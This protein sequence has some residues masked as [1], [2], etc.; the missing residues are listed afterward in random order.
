MPAD[1]L[2]LDLPSKSWRGLYETI[3][4]AV[5]GYNY[6]AWNWS[7]SNKPPSLDPSTFTE[8]FPSDTV[9]V[10]LITGTGDF[11]QDLVNTLNST[12]STRVVVKL[13]GTQA[14][15]QT[16]HITSF[17]PFGTQSPTKPY[18]MGFYNGTK[19]QG[20]LGGGRGASII[21]LDP[22]IYTQAQLTPL[23]TMV[24]ADFAPLLNSFGRLDGPDPTKP[25]LIGGVTFQGGDQP[26]LDTVGSDVPAV[27]PQPAPYQG[28]S[29]YPGSYYV[30]NDCEFLASGHALTSAPPFEMGTVSTQRCRG[31]FKRCD[32]DGRMAASLNPARPRRSTVWMGNDEG[33]IDHIDCWLHHS[34]VSRYA[35]NDEANSFGTSGHYGLLRCRIDHIADTQNVDPAQNGGVSLDGYSDPC[36]LGWESSN[37]QISLVDVII[38]QNNTHTTRAVPQHLGFTSTGRNSAGGHLTVTRGV[39]LNPGFPTVNNFLCVRGKPSNTLWVDATTGMDKTATVTGYDG[40][41]LKGRMYSG[42]WPPPSSFL[43]QYDPAKDYIIKIN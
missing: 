2:V 5:L 26:L 24:S 18:L 11:Y 43:S 12:S 13:P 37:A 29:F 4:E 39:F 31:T 9:Y 14:N 34:N 35:A 17:R 21:Q 7:D 6:S 27:V 19:L 10:N 33:S 28:L 20:F 36:C 23:K 25:I 1:R 8:G 30:V 42:S 15:P 16:Q 22:N 41:V 38:E 32:F 3:A 40:T